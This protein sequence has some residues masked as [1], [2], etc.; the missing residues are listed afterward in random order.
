MSGIPSGSQP[1]LWEAPPTIPLEGP[2]WRGDRGTGE[3]GRLRTGRFHLLP[4][5]R[6]S[7]TD[8]QEF[9]DIQE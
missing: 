4:S 9:R 1:G 3:G 6:K 8:S 2:A 5:C 7:Q